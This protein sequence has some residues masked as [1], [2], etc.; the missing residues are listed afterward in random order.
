MT[1]PHAHVMLRLGWFRVGGCEYTW[2]GDFLDG[3]STGHRSLERAS[4]H[5]HVL[6][7]LFP[8]P[9]SVF[10]YLSLS[11][12]LSFALSHS[13]SLCLS[14][15]RKHPH[16]YHSPWELPGSTKLG[17]HVRCPA[18]TVLYLYI[19]QRFQEEGVGVGVQEWR[20][21]VRLTLDSGGR[22]VM[23]SLPGHGGW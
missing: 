11:I 14:L 3:Q 18:L 1:P 10:L 17:L 6:S 12:S 4:W 2:H 22:C 5:F 19:C 16:T 9:L 15:S 20:R 21:R 7:P 8:S 13:V 23:A